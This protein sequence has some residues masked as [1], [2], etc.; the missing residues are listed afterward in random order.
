MYTSPMLIYNS[1]CPMLSPKPR[2]PQTIRDYQKIQM[3]IKNNGAKV[4]KVSQFIDKY[5]GTHVT[6]AI[7]TS[8]AKII[9]GKYALRLDRLAR[10]N[11]SALLCWYAENWD[12]IYPLLCDADFEKK[13]KYL[14]RSIS[15]AEINQK[16]EKPVSHVPTMDYFDP[17]DL[18]NLLNFH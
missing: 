15:V 1:Q 12:I 8:L 6:I 18:M 13:V 14:K 5:F 3:R 2:T 17:S 16:L 10:R 4:E 9:M 11:R 7:L